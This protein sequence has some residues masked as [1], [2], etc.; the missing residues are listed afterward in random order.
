M[1]SPVNQAFYQ[2]IQT[3]RSSTAS[4][5][6]QISK[7][8]IVSI[9]NGTLKPGQKLIGT[10]RLSELL[11]IHRNT[12]TAVYNELAEQG[13][14]DV[15]PN[16]GAFISKQ[17]PEQ[18]AEERPI[19]QYPI[20]TG[21]DFQQSILLD[22]PFEYTSCEFLLNDGIPDIR[23][24]SVEI[25]SH[26]YSANLKRKGN[27]K[28][29]G[30]YNQEGSEYFKE[31]LVHYLHGSRNFHIAPE[32]ILIT[33]SIEMSL[34]IISEIVLKPEDRV[35][36]GDL[37]YFEANMIFQKSGS[38][39]HTI[40]LDE[41]GISAKALRELCLRE[42][43][44]MLYITPQQHYPTTIS[45][46]FSRKME[47]LQLAYEFGFI[48]LEDDHDYDFQYSKQAALPLSSLDQ[49]GMCIYISSFGKSLAPGFRT[50]FIV[51]PKNLM[52]E[53]RKH[54]GIIDRQGDILMEQALGEMIEEGEIHRH[55]K[56]SIKIYKER[57]DLFA[58]LLKEELGEFISFEVPSGGLA[59]WITWNTP[60]NLMK[61]SKNALIQDVFIPKT[62]L[63]QQNTIC[64]MRI[65]FGD[66]DFSEMKEVMQRF[67]IAV[68]NTIIVVR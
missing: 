68:L 67:R 49:K 45:M 1:N 24:T 31:Q 44:R 51:C 7:Q 16:K 65:G 21:F 56:K 4:L 28:K 59:F 66:L 57:R 29:M 32:N 13:W 60:I 54:L 53:M 43:I 22:N 18:N 27:R 36:V 55:I 5:Y 8:F 47:I 40:P 2:S 25:L 12:A 23:L 9:S 52:K 42:K 3:D 20:R 34:Y 11:G 10:R 30:Y 62:L 63:Y 26:Y 58:D 14:I 37:S 38:K 46:S 19:K 39:I 41:E 33:R 15:F 64:G 50:G 61:L 48:I 35:V 17:L 6:L